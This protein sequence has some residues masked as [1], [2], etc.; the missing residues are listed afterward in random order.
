MKEVKISTLTGAWK[1][2][3]QPLWMTLRGSRFLM[4]GVTADVVGL[5][6]VEKYKM[7]S[8]S[9]GQHRVE[10]R[11]RADGS[12]FKIKKTVAPSLLAMTLFMY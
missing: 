8:F 1:K 11:A 6:R 7:C 5:T 3:I 9:T 4:E 2:L 12:E 10:G